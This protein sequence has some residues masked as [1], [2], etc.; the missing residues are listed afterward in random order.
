VIYPLGDWGGGEMSGV[1][2]KKRGLKKGTDEN[3]KKW[4]NNN[5]GQKKISI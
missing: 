3:K 1:S 2:E 4:N 5:E